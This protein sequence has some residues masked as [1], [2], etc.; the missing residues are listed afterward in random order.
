MIGSKFGANTAWLC[1]LVQA[2]D[3]EDK[4]TLGRSTELDGMLLKIVA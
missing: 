1:V 2:L 3:R 4:L